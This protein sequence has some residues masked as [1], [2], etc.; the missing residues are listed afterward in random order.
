MFKADADDCMLVAPPSLWD[1]QA[2]AV[3]E[4]QLGTTQGSRAIQSRKSGRSWRRKMENGILGP[5]IR[6]VFVSKERFKYG[7]GIANS[8]YL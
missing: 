7:T 8:S 1:M 6:D 3:A 2:M 5:K 4:A